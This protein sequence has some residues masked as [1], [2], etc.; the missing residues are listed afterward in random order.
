M[1]SSGLD[2]Q[3]SKGETDGTSALKIKSPRMLF[4][5]EDVREVRRAEEYW[6]KVKRQL[7]LRRDGATVQLRREL[8]DAAGVTRIGTVAWRAGRWQIVASTRFF[9][10]AGTGASDRWLDAKCPHAITLHAEERTKHHT[11]CEN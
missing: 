2:Q 5:W 8:A 6:S 4:A 7:E 10:A 1:A 9:L 3:R 11:E